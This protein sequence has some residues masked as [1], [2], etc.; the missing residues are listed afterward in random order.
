[1]YYDCLSPSNNFRLPCEART[2]RLGNTVAG[3]T[4]NALDQYGTIKCINFIRRKVQDGQDVKTILEALSLGQSGPIGSD[5]NLEPVLPN[6][7]L[8][9]LDY[10]ED[11]ES[12]R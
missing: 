5:A 11:S 6:D 10:E 1:M 4:Q 2:F 9:F 12:A 7:S 8:L 3:D